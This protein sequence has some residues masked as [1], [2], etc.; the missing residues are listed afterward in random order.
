VW[1]ALDPCVELPNRSLTRS[2]PL[3]RLILTRAGT[4]LD[5]FADL[6]TRP[7]HRLCIAAFAR[8]DNT[9]IKVRN[10]T[11][12]TSLQY[13]ADARGGIDC[14]YSASAQTTYS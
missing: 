9:V 1:P 11:L 6:V 2:R 14:E 10:R 5:S 12:R 3:G 13:Q 4:P 7:G 8:D